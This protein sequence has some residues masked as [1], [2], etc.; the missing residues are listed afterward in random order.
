M[1]KE[2][3][4]K[5]ERAEKKVKEIKDFYNHLAWFLVVNIVVFIVRFKMLDIFSVEFDSVGKNITNWIDV[6]MTI[7]PLLWLFGL[8]CHGLYVFK[9]KFRFYENWE[10]RQ[11]EKYMEEDNDTKYM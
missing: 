8:S 10:Q 1:K 11:I 4:S 9:D 2:P 5:L 6:N 3:L 7:M